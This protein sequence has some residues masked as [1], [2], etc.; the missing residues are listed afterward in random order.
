MSVIITYPHANTVS[1][2]F[3]FSL[4]RAVVDG[5]SGVDPIVKD[6]R[7]I[8]CYP[9][10]GLIMGRNEAMRNFLDSD[11]EWLWTLDTDMGFPKGTLNTMLAHGKPVVSA[12]YQTI[13]EEGSDGMGGPG[14]FRKYPLALRKADDGRYAPLASYEGVMEVDAVGGGCLLI[15]RDAAE[16]VQK[17]F[18]NNWWS[19]AHPWGDDRTLGEDFSFC[20]RLG[21]VGY[22]ITLDCTIPIT[23]HKQVWI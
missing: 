6:V 3:H 23:H 18:G 7:P 1:H 2:N 21:E 8:R 16:A 17:Q 14:T 13:L 4:M 10:D 15:H 12:L 9:G 19:I 20:S 5:M 11:A 22:P